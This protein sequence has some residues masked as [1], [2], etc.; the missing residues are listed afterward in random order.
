[1]NSGIL[2]RRSFSSKYGSVKI[3]RR[4]AEVGDQK[5]ELI[6]AEFMP[7]TTIGVF[8]KDLLG[9][10]TK[11]KVYITGN[12]LERKKSSFPVEV[13]EQ[14]IIIDVLADQVERK[15]W[16]NCPFHKALNQESYQLAIMRSDNVDLE[17]VYNG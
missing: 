1:M 12:Q 16:R 10:E 5:A 8:P 4:Y 2:R 9:T 7:R 14:E 11:K 15:Y 17:D 6:E 3:T 13:P